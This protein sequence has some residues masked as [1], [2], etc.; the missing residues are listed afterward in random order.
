MIK[1]D[2]EWDKKKEKSNLKKHGVSF[3]EAK[4]VFYDE[5][6]IHFLDPDHSDTEDRFILLGMS[7]KLRTVV[8]CHC[9]RKVETTIQII[10]ARKANKKEEKEYWRKR[11]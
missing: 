4:T 11:K 2:F 6:A 9:F 10:S 5:H 1:I 8:V 7:F 3:D